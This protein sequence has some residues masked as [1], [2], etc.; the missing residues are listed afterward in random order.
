MSSEPKQPRPT[1]AKKQSK[2]SGT[3]SSGSEHPLA[4][5]QRELMASFAASGLTVTTMEPQTGT[6]KY[7]VN[8]IPRTKVTPAPKATAICPNCGAVIDD[9]GR[10]RACWGGA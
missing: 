9:D 10:C 6:A 8:F 3:P 5:M 7:M 4:K 2:D 1:K